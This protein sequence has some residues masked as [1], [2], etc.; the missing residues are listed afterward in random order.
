[1]GIQSHINAQRVGRT[2]KFCDPIFC[3]ASETDE[4]ERDAAKAYALVRDALCGG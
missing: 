2:R 4:V 3:E 1:M